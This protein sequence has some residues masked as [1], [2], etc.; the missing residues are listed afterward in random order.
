MEF[1]DLTDLSVTSELW[2]GANE[3]AAHKQMTYSFSRK[4]MPVSDDL[5]LAYSG[6]YE[7]LS[8]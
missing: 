4:Q 7:T 2:I 3:S 6:P 8:S 1:P 5:S